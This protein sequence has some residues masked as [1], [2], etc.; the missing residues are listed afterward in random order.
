MNAI[1][2]LAQKKQLADAAKVSVESGLLSHS[3][4]TVDGSGK[5]Q[6]T[7]KETFD[8]KVGI[9]N[10]NY[11]VQAKKIDE[12]STKSHNGEIKLYTLYMVALTNNPVYD[13]TYLTDKYG[14]APAFMSIIPGVGQWYKG[15]KVKGSL[16]FV[17]AAA[18]VAGILVCENQR[19]AY[20]K[21]MIEQP[22][23]AKEYNSKASNYETGRN[24][25]IGVAAGV[26]IY[27]IVDALVAPGA[28]RVIVEPGKGGGLSMTPM[29]TPE[30]AGISLA[31]TF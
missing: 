10:Q 22:K 20:H 27:S 18:S 9:A 30:Y 28:R 3:E 5:E 21:K 26:W 17:G 25:C 19:A 2:E 7:I 23:F 15:S 8:I 31:Y 6:E 13:K 12:Y 14:A 24:I 1:H 29:F 4:T 11:E 16:M